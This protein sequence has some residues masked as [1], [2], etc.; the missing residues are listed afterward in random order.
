MKKRIIVF[1]EVL[2]LIL[3]LVVLTQ[4]PIWRSEEFRVKMGWYSYGYEDHTTYHKCE[5]NREPIIESAKQALAEAKGLSSG[6][7]VTLEDIAPFITNSEYYFTGPG[8]PTGSVPPCPSGGKYA[9]NP[10]GITVACSHPYHQWYNC[11]HKTDRSAW[12]YQ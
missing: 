1:I 11:M 6:T 3:S 2:A 10:I 12:A 8:V 9:I 5:W 7:A 4:M